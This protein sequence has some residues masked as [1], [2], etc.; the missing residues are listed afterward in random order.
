[1]G[2]C[3]CTYTR[4]ED[5]N[6]DGTHKVVKAVREEIAKAIEA[7]EIRPSIENAVGMQMMAVKIARG[8]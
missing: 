3:V 6:C 7:I 1:M 2:S 8:N 4:D 5:K